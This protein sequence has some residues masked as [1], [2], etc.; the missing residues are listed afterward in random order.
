MFFPQTHA[1][2]PS[3]QQLSGKPAALRK[4]S[5]SGNE[6]AASEETN[7]QGTTILL[8]TRIAKA[9]RLCELY[10]A[11]GESHVMSHDCGALL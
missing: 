7:F 5:I 10:V 2:N 6:H 11:H 3:C 1:G 4:P 8:L 9:K